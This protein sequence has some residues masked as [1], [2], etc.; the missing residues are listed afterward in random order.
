MY[1]SKESYDT[2]TVEQLEENIE[3]LDWTL[4]PRK[5]FTHELQA[6]F[7]CVSKLR[8]RVWFD[9]ILDQITAKALEEKCPDIIFLFI[10]K[11][12]YMHLNKYTGELF[13]SQ[14]LIWSYFIEDFK[15]G[16]DGTY[17]FIKDMMERYL[18]VME[19]PSNCYK[20]EEKHLVQR[21]IKKLKLTPIEQSK[22]IPYK[23][24]L[25]EQ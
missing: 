14:T 10:D 11:R 3:F 16:Y 22:N 6:K 24:E 12:C 13:C 23:L 9:R 21:N 4:V 8:A 2:L 20:N 5:M 7:S 17:L 19:I 25:L 15:M 1:L 18:Q